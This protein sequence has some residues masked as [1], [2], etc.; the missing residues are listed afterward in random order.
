MRDTANR[1]QPT[2]KD[3]EARTKRTANALRN[4]EM[5]SGV[6]ICP[7]NQALKWPLLAL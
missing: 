6:E 4:A 7:E 1:L 2:Q 3:C 5:S